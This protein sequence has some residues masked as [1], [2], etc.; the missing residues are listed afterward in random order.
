MNFHKKFI[1]QNDPLQNKV[2]QNEK[3]ESTLWNV[4]SKR[5]HRGRKKLIGFSNI[6]KIWSWTEVE[7]KW[8]MTSRFIQSFLS[9]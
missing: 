2:L 1:L 4:L 9:I 7:P 6:K 5:C 3:G 8:A